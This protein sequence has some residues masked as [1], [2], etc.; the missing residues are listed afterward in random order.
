VIANGTARRANLFAGVFLLGIA[1]AM[2]VGTGGLPAPGRANDPG[3][4]GYPRLLAIA[5]AALAIAL[6]FQ[7]DKGT[8][9]LPRGSDARRVIAILV[10]LLVYVNILAALGFILATALF[11]VGA[12]ALAGVRH[13]APLA[14][15]P[16]VFSAAV[17]YVFSVTLR[18]S[19]PR[20]IVE[21]FLS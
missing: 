7:R 1:V 4:A 10:M 14:T 11:L 15:V 8:E 19:L 16:I 18:V 21:R 20:G 12:L 17:Y 2:L 5:I 13:P 6:L 3:A 9:R